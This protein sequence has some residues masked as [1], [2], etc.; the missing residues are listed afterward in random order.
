[1]I[2]TI[3]LISLV[4]VLSTNASKERVK[5]PPEI[6]AKINAVDSQCVK[7]VGA[8]PDILKKIIP[9][10][11]PD[12]DINQKYLFC[13]SHKLQMAN[14]NGTFD[15][16]K[17]MKIFANSNRLDDIRKNFSE[18]NLKSGKTKYETIYII[19]NCFYS[20]VGIE[21]TM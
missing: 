21:L 13:L 7:D 2:Y 3:L 1:M 8:P 20:N 19:T 5:V 18:C 6:I 11:L 15:A 12:D 9:W 14:D 4:S 16:D 17:T 10:N